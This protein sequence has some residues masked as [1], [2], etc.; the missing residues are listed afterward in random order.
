MLPAVRGRARPRRP[1]D[2]FGWKGWQSLPHKKKMRSPPLRHSASTSR[3]ASLC[4]VFHCNGAGAL[5][6]VGPRARRKL[7]HKIS[8]APVG[9]SLPRARPQ[10]MARACFPWHS[11]ACDNA[12]NTAGE[13][14]S[15][16]IDKG[17]PDVARGLLAFW[18]FGSDLFWRHA[19]QSRS[20]HP[21]LRAEQGHKW[22]S[23]CTILTALADE[24]EKIECPP[25]SP[26]SLDR[27]GPRRAVRARCGLAPHRVASG[28]ART[29][30]CL[31]RAAE[32]TSSN[33]KGRALTQRTETLAT[34]H[35]NAVY[36]RSRRQNR[37]WRHGVDRDAQRVC[38]RTTAHASFPRTQTR[39]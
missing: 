16:T 21:T 18:T 36:P 23:A 25:S 3:A 9:R 11:C 28:E 1:C 13:M 39:G 8:R 19:I 27:T 5:R 24:K 17:R 20:A 32:L 2:N 29:S 10:Q 22:R 12:S 34:S 26:L 33:H 30:A 4:K 15:R 38:A 31:G 37:V 7:R 14:C 35:R 6:P